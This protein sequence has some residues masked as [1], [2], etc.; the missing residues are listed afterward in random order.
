[1]KRFIAF[2]SFSLAL[3]AACETY[4]PGDIS[5]GV[6][7]GIFDSLIRYCSVTTP[8]EREAVLRE[9]QQN[10]PGYN[11]PEDICQRFGLTDVEPT[12]TPSQTQEQ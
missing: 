10:H 2:G 9:I 3:L 5:A 6:S 8:W 11:P 1:M 7:R 4:E 12:P